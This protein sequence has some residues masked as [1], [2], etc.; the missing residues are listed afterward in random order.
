MFHLNQEQQRRVEYGA[1]ELGERLVLSYYR[2][3]SGRRQK[4]PEGSCQGV[5]NIQQLSWAFNGREKN[6][7]PQ[8][9]ATP[10]TG[11]QEGL[12]SSAYDCHSP[13]HVAQQLGLQ[14]Q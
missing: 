8:A 9:L 14:D 2:D 7:V 3:G 6:H 11:E 12:S 4:S 5:N 10:P 1:V 13:A